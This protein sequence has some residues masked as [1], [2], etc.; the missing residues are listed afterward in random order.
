MGTIIEDGFL[1]NLNS[2]SGT[3]LNGTYNSNVVFNTNGILKDDP[4]ICYS[5]NS[6][7]NAQIPVS[8][9]EVNYANNV[10]YYNISSTNYSITIP[11]GNYNA[12]TLITQLETQFLAN[13][14]TFTITLN[15]LTAIL[16]F[17]N[18]N[19]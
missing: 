5:T 14:H 10:L 11:V 13:S 12:N 19:I 1:I 2:A 17:A 7:L 4:N 3:S 9:Y 15:S 18:Y 16:T 8:M 6:L